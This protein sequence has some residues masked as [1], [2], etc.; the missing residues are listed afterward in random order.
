MG[1]QWV[2]GL[3]LVLLS[4]FLVAT[5]H[6]CMGAQNSTN[7]CHEQ[8]RL[9]LLEFKHSVKDDFEMLSSWVGIDCCSWKGVRCDG[10]TGRVVGLHLRGNYGDSYEF[11]DD[12]YEEVYYLEGDKMNACL[13]ELRHLQH[14]DLSGN[15][16]KESQIPEFIGSFKQ[17]SYLN[18]SNA[19]FSGIIPHHIGNLSNLKVLDLGSNYM[20]TTD[21]MAWVSGLSSLEH[22]DLSYVHL[23]QANNVDMVFYMIPSLTYLSLSECGL[24]NADLGL[25]LNSSKIL[26]NIEHLDLSSNSFEGQLPH[27]FQNLTSLTFLDISFYNLSLAWNSVNLLSTIPSLSELHL[28]Q[29]GLHN[30]HFSPTYLNSSAHSNIQ[31]LDLSSNSIG[32][33]FP[34]ELMN[35]TSLKV[36]DLSD[37]SLNSSIPVMPNL[38]K[39]DLSFNNFEHIELVGIWRQCHLKELS[40][41][42]N[43]F[44]GEMIGPSSNT[45]ECSHYAL[46]VLE[47]DEND[48]NGSLPESVGKLNNLRVLSLSYSSFTGSIPKALERLRSLEALDLS[49]N[50]LTGPVPTFLGNLTKLDLSYNQFS[51]SITES[52]G[53]LTDLTRLSLQSNLLTGPIP[54][55]LGRLIGLTHL[56]LQSNLLTGP[57]PVTVGQLTK[58][59]RLDISNNSLEGVVL[60]AHFANLSMLLSLDTS[61]NHK[62]IF[63]VSHEWIPP[64]IQLKT[65][66]LSSCKILNGFPH[67]LQNQRKLERLELSNASLYGLLPTWL[68]NMSMLLTLDLS[69]NKLIGSLIH[70][71]FSEHTEILLLQ[72][73]H[74]NGSIPRSLCRS[75]WFDILDVSGNQLSGNIPDCVEN[76]QYIRMLILGSNGLS[77]VIPSSFGNI[78]SSLQW[79]KLNDNNFNGQIPQNLRNLTSLEVLDL[80]NNEFSGNIPK[81]I[82]ENL[83]YLVVL[84][85]HKNNFTGD[86]PHSLCKC[87][88]LHILD[89]AH[90]N[91]TGSIPHCFGELSAM[92]NVTEYFQQDYEKNVTVVDLIQ[93]IKGI[94]LDYTTTMGLVVNMDLSSNKL[95]GE[96]PVELTALASLMG[97]NLSHNHL[98]G[99]IPDSIGNMKALTSLDFSDNQLNGTIP[100]SMAALNFLSS[101]N[102][103]HNNLSGSIPTGNQLRTLIDPSIYAG[104]KDLCGAPLPNNCSNPENPPATTNKIKYKKANGQ[105][106][107]WFY[108]DITCGFATGF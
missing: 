34:S 27:F 36:I 104:N 102:L 23:S 57:I 74:F 91:L 106:N 107:V 39:L 86:I 85:L 29:C 99:S 44:G 90:N 95:T 70:L 3:H 40:V 41:S 30:A 69:H 7:S 61:A 49:Q 79:L 12:Y 11:E 97:L 16:F 58:L 10:A 77:G 17:L 73:N 59:V 26:P 64:F 18:L 80:G 71:P 22:L 67:W 6:T 42:G 62:L 68:Q 83:T 54:E 4:M 43:L 24:T 51:G 105:R 78:A 15:Y 21:D 52:L 63:N 76:L 101:M 87:S 5:K 75:R 20:L 100:P 66:Q 82:G 32:V 38:L 35:I 72:D 25:H 81:W 94:T 47:A 13:A 33:R 65:V 9:A 48:L 37:N 96:I 2:W 8:E 45:S 46:E 50:Q 93:V 103:S 84:R 31:H 28:S 19:Y 1:N 55:S 98:S 60:E 53:R 88:H 56:N 92:N 108:L 89:I 14:L